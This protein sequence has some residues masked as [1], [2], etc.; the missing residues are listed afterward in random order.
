ME[1]EART[2]AEAALAAAKALL[3]AAL[4]DAGGGAGSGQAGQ[5]AGRLAALVAATEHLSNA[6]EALPAD[7]AATHA[8]SA[9][10]WVAASAGQLASLLDRALAEAAAARASGGG[11]AREWLGLVGQAA[12]LLDYLDQVVWLDQVL[13]KG[14]VRHSP[15]W[16][17]VEESGDF[18]GRRRVEDL[19]RL[20][21]SADE[22]GARGPVDP[23]V[24]PLPLLAAAVLAPRPTAADDHQ[25]QTTTT[26]RQPPPPISTNQTNNIRSCSWSGPRRRRRGKRALRWRATRAGPCPCFM[27]CLRG[28]G[29]RGTGSQRVALYWTLPSPSCTR[30]VRTVRALWLPPIPQQ[31]SPAPRCSHL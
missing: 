20:W 29:P 4:A 21:P 11:G 14:E 6:L 1:A 17:L 31:L 9:G 2:A 10:A 23:S 3:A 12:S 28:W 22:V 19:A 16:T 25:Q 24:V 15:F 5:L 26:N 30:C 18:G 7:Q 13:A 8:A 27:T